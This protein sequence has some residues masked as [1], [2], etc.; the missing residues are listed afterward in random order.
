MRIGI[1]GN[2]NNNHFVLYRYL[3]DLNF[4]ITLFILSE[5]PTH[6][7]PE[8]DT[9]SRE[10]LSNV[11]LL[12]WHRLP[13]IFT[14]TNFETIPREIQGFDF[15]IATGIAAAYLYKYGI[16]IDVFVPYGSDI[17]RTAFFFK[18]FKIK[19]SKLSKIGK[20]YKMCRAQYKGINTSKIILMEKTNKEFE[21]L[22]KIFKPRRVFK[23]L[24]M[25]YCP[26]YEKQCFNTY[27]SSS[28]HFVKCQQ[29]LEGISFVVLQHCRQHWDEEKGAWAEK[30]NNYLIQAFANLV[31]T[32]PL[33]TTKLILLEYGSSVDKSKKLIQKLDI[34]NNVIWLPILERKEIMAIISL[35]DVVVGELY[36]SWLTYGCVF[37]SLVMKKPFIHH[38]KVDLYKDRYDELYSMY[39]ASTT[40]EVYE[41]L[42]K[43]SRKK[44]AQPHS[45][46]IEQNTLEWYNQKCKQPV[47]DFFLENFEH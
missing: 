41:Q 13:N 5:E 28:S 19:N 24:P 6:F 31:K 8:A 35:S 27:F 33:L 1:F 47:I 7:R 16:K 17:Y 46:L 21:K 10:L 26:E 37:E 30:A 3:K 36:R 20:Y 22:I 45:P 32:Q 43:L 38:C 34:Q 40:D 25:V 11:K 44:E 39:P 14:A 2:M 18:T 42:V 29:L 4:D 9:F 15:I 23:S 12:P